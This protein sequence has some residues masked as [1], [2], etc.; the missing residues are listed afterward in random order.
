MKRN[1]FILVGAVILLA[2]IGITIA[3][4]KKGQSQVPAWQTTA[5]GIKYRIEKE[6]T[7][8]KTPSPGD[9]VQVHYTGWLDTDGKQ[10]KKF[11]SSVD[12][13]RPFSFEVGN[14]LVIKG[15][16]ESVLAMKEGEKR[17]VFIPSELGYGSRNAGSIP[18]NSTLRFEIELL[19]IG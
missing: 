11:D 13:G 4:I 9:M 12:R 7:S 8:D 15:W 10:G 18:A 5:S 3:A 14:G 19:K 16:D 1:R 2:G 6:G 17:Y